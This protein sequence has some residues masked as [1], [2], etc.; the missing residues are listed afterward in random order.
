M[1]EP[2][3]FELVADSELEVKKL[4]V[5]FSSIDML[6]NRL[7]KMKLA[8]AAENYVVLKQ[9]DEKLE[10]VAKGLGKIVEEI[11]TKT[12]PTLFERDKLTSCNTK[13]GY[14]VGVSMLTRASMVDKEAAKQWLKDN[15]LGDIV[16]E[17]VNAQTLAA[18]AKT[19]LEDGKELD[20]EL[21]NVILVPTT[22]VTKIKAK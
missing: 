10:D 6:A 21:F 19:L 3:L 18:T 7:E 15:G 20:P 8:D 14:R 11:K 1:S 16:T 22:S 5:L 12:M 9:L 17:T 4:E 2:S 13:M